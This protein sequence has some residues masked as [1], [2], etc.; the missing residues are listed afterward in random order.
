L[1]NI[2]VKNEIGLGGG[3]IHVQNAAYAA[4]H[5]FQATKVRRISVCP[6]LL[7]ELAGPNMS[8]SGAVFSDL[9]SCD[10]LS[11]MVS[12]VWQPHSRL[13]FQAAQCFFALRKA[14]PSLRSFYTALDQEALDCQAPRRQLTFP[15]P[16]S[17]TSVD[18]NTMQ[19]SY[20]EK[21]TSLCYRATVEQQEGY[22]FV[23][24]C[25]A[26]N[27]DAHRLLAAEGFAPKLLGI[28][29]LTDEWQ[30][31]IMEYVTGYVWE[32]ADEKPHA[33]LEAAVLLLH[34]AGFVHGDL[35]SNNVLVVSGSVCVI[36][37]EWSGVAEQAVYPG[38]MNHVDVT[39]PDGARSGLPI[40]KA[41]DL[42]WVSLL[43]ST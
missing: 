36:D 4:M 29:S 16:T 5:A 2:E 22:V 3:A 23:K 26:Y 34:K 21:L 35:R 15:Y 38:F 28:R 39:W 17:F 19:L 42:W 33:A 1:V 7:I 8:L 10:Q 37:F 32:E 11:P 20:E 9:A 43:L 40:R 18:G 27:T 41:H 13:M 6:T 14:L 12:L 24:F 30:M 31:V 25:K